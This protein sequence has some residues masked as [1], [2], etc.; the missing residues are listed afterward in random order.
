MDQTIQLVPLVCVQCST[1]IPAELHEAAWVC[2]QCGQGMALDP[3][4]GL[5]AVPVYYTSG[6]PAGGSGKPYWVADGQV[7]LRRETY[8]SNSGSARE[9]E[10]FWSAPRR[11]FVPAYASD[12][13]TLLRTGVS[14]LANPPALQ[15]GPAMPFQAVTLSIEDIQPAAEFIVMAVEA[16]RKDALKKVSFSLKLSQPALWILP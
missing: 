3:A 4:K 14:L 12:T 5:L 11:F 6:I 7:T 13:E 9:A 10:Q 1:P 15:T 2:A 16:G 8:R